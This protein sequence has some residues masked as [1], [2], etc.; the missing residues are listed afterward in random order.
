M[1]TSGDLV[2]GRFESNDDD[3]IPYSFD[4]VGRERDLTKGLH[5]HGR[6]RM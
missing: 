6:L 3:S 1:K 5:L 4:A 2:I